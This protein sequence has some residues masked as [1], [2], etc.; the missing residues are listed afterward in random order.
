M[1]NKVEE[2]DKI[3][4]E[5][6]KKNAD[7]HAETSGFTKLLKYNNP[8]IL[9]L[10]AVIASCVQGASMPIL[11]ILIAKFMFIT[12]VPLDTLEKYKGE[13]YYWD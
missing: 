11:G 3:Y 5:E 2:S 12:T 8:K 6:L 13:T 9:I 7:K 4:D 10:V 1:K